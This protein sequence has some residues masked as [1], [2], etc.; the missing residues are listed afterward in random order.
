METG[1]RQKRA[2]I[3]LREQLNWPWAW[4]GASYRCLDGWEINK[5]R[6]ARDKHLMEMGRD[7]GPFTIPHRN[8]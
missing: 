8:R 3:D 6:V 4:S 5:N 2:D 1:K 7:F